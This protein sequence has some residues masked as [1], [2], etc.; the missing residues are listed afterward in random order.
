MKGQAF[1]KILLKNGI[2][3]LFLLSFVRKNEKWLFIN[4]N[5]KKNEDGRQNHE[6]SVAIQRYAQL[7]IRFRLVNKGWN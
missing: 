4:I 3:A 7:S 6:H 1:G 2:N 5:R